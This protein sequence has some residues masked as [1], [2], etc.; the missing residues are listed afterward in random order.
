[1]SYTEFSADVT[2]S[3]TTEATAQA[4]V[5]APAFT[6]NGVDGYII[7]FNCPRVDVAATAG[8]T[9]IACLYDNGAIAFGGS[10]ATMGQWTS[11]AAVAQLA[12]GLCRSP[13]IVP[14]AVAH[15]Y[16]IRFYRSGN[17]GTVRAGSSSPN[18][19]VLVTKV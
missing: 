12:P 5:T 8:A 13:R 9:L 19:Y 2:I 16:S 11:V 3:A 14:T 15:A 18:G 10:N 17:N 4:I 1:V 7:E 6:P